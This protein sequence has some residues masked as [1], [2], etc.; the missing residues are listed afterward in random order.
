MKRFLPITA[1]A[2]FAYPAATI[3]CQ[4][5]QGAAN[6]QIFWDG[7]AIPDPVFRTYVLENFD[8][9]RDGKIS[10][11]EADAVLAIDLGRLCG[12]S[13]DTPEI[14]SLAG[15]E[16]FRNLKQLICNGHALTELDLSKNTELNIL[17]CKDNQLT[18]LDLSE[19]TALLTL[20]CGRNPIKTLDLTENRALSML[21]C[22]YNQLT[23]FDLSQNTA[24]TQLF[25]GH[26]QLTALD[27]SE[28]TMLTDLWCDYNQLT[29][30]DLS[31]N[32]ALT[33]LYCGYNR[34]TA[35]DLSENTELIRL[36]CSDNPLI[37]L[38]LSDLA[39]LEA[40]SFDYENHEIQVITNSQTAFVS[41]LTRYM[42]SIEAEKQ[43]K[44]RQQEE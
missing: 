15:V 39:K 2:V 8:T 44:Y 41:D 21:V 5:G 12:E 38:N 10:R 16:H 40:V 25:C 32:A 18:T 30:L 29:A 9:D 31:E 23:A 19:N 24:L 26:N 4:N 43:K 36:G 17:K 28:N 22:D 20:N 27:L 1:L 11:K 42:Q 33:E 34:L 35:L 3:S 14:E 13:S 6:P 37:R 7:G